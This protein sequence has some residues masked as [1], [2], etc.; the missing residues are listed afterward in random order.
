MLQRATKYGSLLEI[1]YPDD[2]HIIAV[3]PQGV[4]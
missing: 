2:G 1:E 3:T 4:Q